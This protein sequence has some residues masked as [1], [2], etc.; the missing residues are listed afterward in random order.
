[1]IHLEALTSEAKPLFPKLSFFTGF[2]LAGGTSIA[3]QLGHRISVDFDM[4]SPEPIAAK[5]LTKAEQ[6]FRQALTPTVIIPVN[7]LF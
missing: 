1:M 7:L 3:L 4:F 6:V 5:L 2:Y